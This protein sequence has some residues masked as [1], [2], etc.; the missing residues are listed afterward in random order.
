[1]TTSESSKLRILIV[2]DE[3]LI[4]WSL[5]QTLSDRGHLVAETDTAETTFA[6]V[7]QATVPFDVALLD[8]LLPDSHD[9]G[10]TRYLRRVSPQTQI[11]LMTALG[12]PEIERQAVEAGVYRIVGKPFEIGAVIDLVLEAHRS[13]DRGRPNSTGDSSARFNGSFDGGRRG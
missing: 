9:L 12:T 8:L 13:R 3:P 5:A 11:I 6:A 10:V 2:D 7:S 4:R 1:M